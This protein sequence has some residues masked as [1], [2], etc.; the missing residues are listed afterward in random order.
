VLSEGL[1]HLG[2]FVQAVRHPCGVDVIVDYVRGRRAEAA[3]QAAAPGARLV[4]VGPAASDELRLSAAAAWGRSLSVLG[5][6]TY[7]APLDVRSAAYRHL[8][9]LAALTARGQL[10]ADSESLPLQQVE[11]AWRRQLAGDR[12]RL[13]LLP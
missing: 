3:L 13:V 4:Q 2:Q 8:A 9:V 6:A 11:S 12:R 1:R 7:H 5:Y 10:T